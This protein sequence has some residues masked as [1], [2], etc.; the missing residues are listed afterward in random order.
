MNSRP[1]KL[2]S[3]P[4]GRASMR[5]SRSSLV[6]VGILSFDMPGLHGRFVWKQNDTTVRP[7]PFS[8]RGSRGHPF[9]LSPKTYR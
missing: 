5:R 3:Q 2:I 9:Q 7:A 6:M 1:E 4:S 8:N